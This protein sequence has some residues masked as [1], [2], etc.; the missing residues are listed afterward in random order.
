MNLCVENLHKTYGKT[1][2]DGIS[3]KISSGETIGILGPN[4]RQ[5]DSLCRSQKIDSGKIFLAEKELNEKSLL[6]ELLLGLL[7]SLRNHQYSED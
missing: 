5:D 7:T 6:R 4:D 2:V 1:I 3:F